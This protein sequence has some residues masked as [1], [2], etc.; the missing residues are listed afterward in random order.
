MLKRVMLLVAL[1]DRAASLAT[2]PRGTPLLFRA[3]GRLK[4]STE[5]LTEF[6]RGRLAGEGDV[7]RSLGRLG[8]RVGHYQ[9]PRREV[10][11]AGAGL[12]RGWA[13]Q[14]REGGRLQAGAAAPV[15]E[16]WGGEMELGRVESTDR[17]AVH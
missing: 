6:L 2:L 16:A 5:V 1:L 7:L 9:H 14:G 4:G 10:N 3:E 11:F 15:V 13:G 17:P 12:G 8:Y